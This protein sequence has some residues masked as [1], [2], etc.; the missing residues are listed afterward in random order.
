MVPVPTY[1]NLFLIFTDHTSES[2]SAQPTSYVHKDK[3]LLIPFTYY[4]FYKMKNNA[5]G[6]GNAVAAIDLENLRLIGFFSIYFSFLYLTC[7]AGVV[8]SSTRHTVLGDRLF[9]SASNT[10][11][12][13][14]QSELVVCAYNDILYSYFYEDGL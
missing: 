3:V 11:A 6:S 5:G 10:L 14:Q 12:G 2:I 8:R 1:S 9:G 7:L 13:S 4:G